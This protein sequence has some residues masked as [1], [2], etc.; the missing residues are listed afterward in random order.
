MTAARLLPPWL[1]RL[2]AQV[3]TA[4]MQLG[5]VLEETGGVFEVGPEFV[6]FGVGDVAF[7]EGGAHMGNPTVTGFGSDGVGVVP[8]AQ[9]G[10]AA[11]FGVGG[12]SA[13]VLFEEQLESALRG[14]EVSWR[15]HG[16]QQ[17]VGGDAVVE[18]GGEFFEERF[19]AHALVCGRLVSWRGA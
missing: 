14:G 10:V 7:V 3:G 1:W 19:P 11:F 6:A 9:A 18:L 12:G 15:V 17:V 4:A 16:P 2:R 13:P 8:H 5:G